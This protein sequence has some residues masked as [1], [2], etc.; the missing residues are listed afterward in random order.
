MPDRRRRSLVTVGLD[1]DLGLS[2]ATDAVARATGA[3]ATGAKAVHSYRERFE[4][5]FDTTAISLVRSTVADDL[6]ITVFADDRK[7]T[8]DVSGRDHDS[9][10]AAVQQ[11]M[12]AAAAGAPDP[13]NVLPELPAAPALSGGDLVPDHDAMVAV[14]VQFL[15]T[16]RRDH[17]RLLSRS[18]NYTFER[19]WTS[20]ANSHGRTQHASR[21]RYGATLVVSG[22]DAASSTSFQYTAAASATPIADLA[23]LPSWRQALEET[24]RSFGAQPVPATFVGDVIVTPQALASLAGSVIEALSGL[25]LI[26]GTSPFAGRLRELVASPLV[27]LAHQP[28]ELAAAAAFDGEGF[29]N[30]PLP[31]ITAGR[32]EHFLIDWYAS[33]KLD[34]PMTTGRGD[35]VVQAG[36]TALADIIA[37]TDRGV[38]L[39]RF[40]G[41]FPN[42]KLDFSG[43]AKNSFYVEAGRVVGPISE[44]M[45]AGNLEA[46]L[47][48]VRA[49]SREEIDSGYYRMPWLA[50]GGVTISTR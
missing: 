45:V 44:T 23:E 29:V 8:A 6:S 37:A 38:V 46:L 19:D 47:R 4:V 43:V 16:L 33:H 40:S 34:Q 9:V 21:G 42:A 5:N 35:F 41:G 26:R 2:V 20:Y 3:G 27:T 15:D 50:A 1:P 14:V 12:M 13:A 49:V 28:D 31:V 18:S 11:A 17:P 36:E 30:E 48:D 10:D 7:G 22:H 39:G 24:E 25:A 32:L